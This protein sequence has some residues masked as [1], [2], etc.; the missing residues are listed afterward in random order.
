MLIYDWISMIALGHDRWDTRRP[1]PKPFETEIEA[2]RKRHEGRKAAKPP[3]PDLL[4][5]LL[6]RQRA[7]QLPQRPRPARPHKQ[8]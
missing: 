8:A 7:F 4:T 5:R 2:A 1:S 6:N 3:T